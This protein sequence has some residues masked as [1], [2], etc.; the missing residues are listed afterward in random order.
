MHGRTHAQYGVWLAAAP[1]LAA[2]CA[3]CC[4]EPPEN[5]FAESFEYG[6][7]MRRYEMYAPPA[8]DPAAPAPVLIALHGKEQSIDDL[9]RVTRFN[10][11][12]DAHGFVVVYPEA[13]DNNWNDGRAVPGVAA[14]DLNVDDVGFVWAVLERIALTRSLYSARAYLV[15]FSNGAMMCQRIAFEQPQRYAAMAGVAGAI[16]ANVTDA[17]TPAVPIPVCMINGTEDSLLPWEGGLLTPQDPQGVVLSVPD[18]V[19]YW[20]TFNQCPAEP[21]V[22]TLPNLETFNCTTV[23]RYTY[24]P[25][26]LDTYVVLYAVEGGGHAWPGACWLQGLFMR[27]RVSR[28]FDASAAIWGFCSQFTRSAR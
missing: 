10:A 3:A 2:L 13:Y 1:L 28:D 9:R 15:G 25:G 27:G 21:V 7:L 5:T 12:A 14:Y 22:E 6:G 11:L 19:G 23:R 8:S 20:I 26:L 16:P 24:G 17:L 4:P 18:S